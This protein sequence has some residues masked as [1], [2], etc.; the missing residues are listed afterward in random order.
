MEMTISYG[1][2]KDVELELGEKDMLDIISSNL[3]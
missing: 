2:I 3:E 1:V